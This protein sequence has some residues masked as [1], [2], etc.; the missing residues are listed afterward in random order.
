MFIMLNLSIYL[1]VRLSAGG[2]VKTLKSCPLKKAGK[3]RKRQ[4]NTRLVRL[5]RQMQ[6][7]ARQRIKPTT[8]LFAFASLLEDATSLLGCLSL[9]FCQDMRPTPLHLPTP[10]SSS[11]YLSAARSGTSVLNDAGG[12]R[13]ERSMAEPVAR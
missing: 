12:G 2:S 13:Q 10:C 7:G 11:I 9:L 1:I 8:F 6:K 5:V 4:E 3:G